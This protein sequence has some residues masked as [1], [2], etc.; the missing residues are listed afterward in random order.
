MHDQYVQYAVV[1]LERVVF[2]LPLR[3]PRLLSPLMPCR[4]EQGRLPVPANVRRG[5]AH[6]LPIHRRR[7]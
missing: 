6:A 7:R 4:F 1:V 3:P 2:A 5:P